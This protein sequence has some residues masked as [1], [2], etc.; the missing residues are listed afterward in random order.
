VKQDFALNHLVQSHTKTEALIILV[1]FLRSIGLCRWY[2]SITI[3]DII[4]L[5]V[6]YLKHDFSETGF[7]LCLQAEPTL[8]IGPRIQYI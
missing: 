4:H 7:C 2:I 8:S 3:L 6:F 1:I 5:P